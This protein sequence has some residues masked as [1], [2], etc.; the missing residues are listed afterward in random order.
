MG[1]NKGY[2][3]VPCYDTEAR[4]AREKEYYRAVMFPA[5]NEEFPLLISTDLVK[6]DSSYR[7][8]DGPTKASVRF[9]NPKSSVG[10]ICSLSQAGL[11]S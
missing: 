8:F 1:P 6:Q 4:A 11:V 3:A 10:L 9:T 7:D 2:E 5:S